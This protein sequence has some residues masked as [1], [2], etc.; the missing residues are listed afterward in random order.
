ME[1][2]WEWV[3][4]RYFFLPNPST[5]RNWGRGQGI[6]VLGDGLELNFSRFAIEGKISFARNS[7]NDC[8]VGDISRILY[9]D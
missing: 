3:R 9:E 7:R 8:H 6:V 5:I 4:W 1:A 2:E